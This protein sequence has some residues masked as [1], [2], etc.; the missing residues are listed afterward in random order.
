MLQSCGCW[1]SSQSVLSLNLRGLE[2]AHAGVNARACSHHEC[3]EH[4]VGAGGIG[5]SDFHGVEMTSYIRSVDVRDGHVKPGAGAADP[6]GRCY[7]G[8]RV[9]QNLAH[10][11]AAGYVPQGT[12]L[13]FAS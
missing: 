3:E 8:F 4:L 2:A 11:V 6:F 5:H 7:D 9:A 13:E 1:L 12:M 10:C